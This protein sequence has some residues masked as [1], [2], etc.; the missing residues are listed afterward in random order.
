MIPAVICCNCTGSAES[1]N[2][3]SKTKVADRHPQWNTYWYSGKAE[4][5][6]YKLQQSRYGELRSGSAVFIFVTEPFSRSKQVKLDNPSSA[7][8][9]KVSVLKLNS[10]RKFNTGI[11]PY[12]LMQSVFT[13][14]DL[15]NNPKTIK[16]SMSGQEWCGH[17]FQQ[18]NLSNEGYDVSQFSYFESEGDKK[19][20]VEYALLEDEIPNRIRISPESLPVGNFNLILGSVYTRLLHK[21]VQSVPVTAEKLTKNNNI[22]DYKIRFKD[23]ER[24][25]TYGFHSSFPFE[26][27]YWSDKYKSPFSGEVLE[28]KAIK[29]ERMKTDYWNRNMDKDLYLRDSLNLPLW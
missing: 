1:K 13:P 5:T 10:T 23:N 27:E 22:T 24:V 29:D 28:T 6:S 4:I 21:N 9:D 3:P 26:I 18:L 16:T 8:D 15:Y 7:G 2:G 20:R 19:Y 11:Y 12:S 17:V 25:I 14:A